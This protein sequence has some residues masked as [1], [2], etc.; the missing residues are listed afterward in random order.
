M[1]ANGLRTAGLMAVLITLFA[2]L[3]YSLGGTNWLVIGFAVAVA[4]NFFSYWY[5]DKIVLRMYGGREVERHEA[6]ALYDMVDRLRQRAGLPMPKVVVL[7]SEQPNAFATGR[8]PAHAAVAVT[9]GIVRL[10]S[11][12]ELEGVIAHEL[13]HIQNRDILTS[14]VAATMGSAI[15]LLAR[16]AIFVPVGGRDDRGGGLSAILM[17]ILAPIAAML[18]QMA[19]SRSREFAADRDGAAISG[20]P[21]ALAT[22]LMRLHEGAEQMPMDAN[23]STAHLFIVS[24]L[25]GR[26]GALR[27]LF[28]THP[29]VEERVARLRALAR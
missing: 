2:L 17:L 7:P 21:H 24:P 10:L 28:A 29:P 12:E 27:G 19:I 16:F 15:T 22:A 26:M 25:A 14:S 5:S 8:N 1:H 23:P 9:N 3:G 6:P 20:D 11:P 18:I 13:A 4:M